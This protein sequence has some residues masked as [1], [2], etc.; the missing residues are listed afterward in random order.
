MKLSIIIPVYRAEATLGRCLKS[1]MEQTFAD[2][3]VILVDDGSPDGCPRLCDEWSARDRRISVIHQSNGGLSAARNAGIDRAKGE[4]ITFIDSDDFIARDTLDS[5]MSRMGDNDLVEYPLWCFY[6]APHQHLLSFTN[7]EYTNT[8]DY[9]LSTEAYRH[10]Y[11]CNKVYRRR[12]FDDIRFPVGHVFEDVYTLPRILKV[13]HKVATVDG[14]L[15]YYC[16]NQQGITATAGGLGLRQ[17]LDAHLTSGMTIDDRYYLY[18]LNIQMDVSELTGDTTRLRHRHV[19]PTGGVKQR[20]KIIAN[21]T[22]GINALCKI[23]KTLHHIK[24]PSRS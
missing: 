15:Y 20:I 10:C 16:W 6:G 22:I 5:V 1:V 2:Y 7:A 14:G 3:E 19:K 12:L 11:A 4:Y 23:S 13:A 8:G 9:W 24:P 18:L 17:L 21:N